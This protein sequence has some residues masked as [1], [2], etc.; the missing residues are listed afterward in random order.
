MVG[1]DAILLRDGID[2]L[3]QHIA[4][5]HEFGIRMLVIPVAMIFTDTA[6]TDHGY[7]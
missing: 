7:T 4:Q 1:R 6:Q 2:P 5:C 3:R